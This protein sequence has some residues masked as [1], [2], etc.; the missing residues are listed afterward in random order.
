MWYN[1]EFEDL[2]NQALV[3]PDTAKRT[4]LYAKAEDIL[5]KQDAVMIPIY[6][7]TSVQLTKI[8]VERTFSVM[9]GKESFNKWDIL[10]EGQ[11]RKPQ[12]T[13][14][15]ATEVPPTEVPPTETEVPPTAT[16]TEVPPTETE[17]PP[18]E[19]PATE[20]PPTETELPVIE[21]TAT[22]SSSL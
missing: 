10:P 16:L 3:E 8:N 17:V 21:S 12:M 5:V 7:Y 13:A 20:V 4:E 18:T 1:Q 19:V 9:G 22:S 15:P 2:V 11:E 6:W 14:V